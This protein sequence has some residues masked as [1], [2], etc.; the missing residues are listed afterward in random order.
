MD[1]VALAVQGHHDRGEQAVAVGR[2]HEHFQRGVVDTDPADLDQGLA[3][4]HRHQ[5]SGLPGQLLGAQADEALIGH[6]RELAVDGG[7]V[8]TLLAHQ[9]AH[10]V[11][12]LGHTLGGGHRMLQPF[13]QRAPGGEVKVGQQAILPGVPQFRAGAGNIGTGQQ[14]QVVQAVAAADQGGEAMD[15]HRVG[16]VL[17]LRGHRHAQVL[18]D[19]PGDQFGIGA[20][21]RMCLAE[22]ARVHRT[23]LGVVAAAA[24]GNVMEQAGQQQ[25]LRLAQARPHF[26][27]DREALVGTAAGEQADVA[28]D[29]QR[30]LVDGVD[31]EQVELHAPAD[32]GERG[33]PLAKH[34]QPRH[35]RKRVDRALATQ[36]G[37]EVLACVGVGLVIGRQQRQR[38]GQRTRGQ[39]VQAAHLR[40]VGP[41]GKQREHLAN[42]ALRPVGL[43]GGQV[44]TTQGKAHGQ[45]LRLRL[46]V[47]LLLEALQQA[48]ADPPHHQRGAVEALHHF[49]DT[50][51]LGVVFEAQARGEGLLVIETQALFRA[52]CY[53]VQAKPQSRQHGTFALERRGF[54]GTQMAEPDQGF[55][56]AHAERAQCHPAQ[57]VE[58]AQATGAILQVRLQVVGGIT[59]ALV[60]VAQLFQLG[61]EESAC[62]PQ[63]AIVDGLAQR[64]AGGVIGQDRTRLD[65]RGQHGLV[66]R[67]LAALQCR[68]HR[69]A[70]RQPAVPQQREQP[71][72]GRFVRQ[73]RRRIAEYQ[74]VDV[75]SREQFTAAIA[76]YREQRQAAA[77]RQ[78]TLP[79]QADQVV[80]SARTQR[81]QALDVVALVEAAVQA[82]VGLLQRLPRRSG[83]VRV[84][85]RRGRRVQQRTRRQHRQETC[86]S[87]GDRVST[88]TPVSVTATMCSHCADSLR[89]L[90]TTVQP[91]GSTL[92]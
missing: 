33:N 39:R 72:Q 69:M 31:M 77:G 70:D 29:H 45:R 44:A 17:L 66:S 37:K 73:L 64:A 35:A 86:D 75:R 78:A 46:A 58:I 59:E 40:V 2:V 81:Q 32:L 50:E 67:R 92:L 16:N 60:T 28:Q 47:E 62:R 15:H 34:A 3:L 23:Q 88:S 20:T 55:Q 8:V 19:Q 10:A 22:R 9:C 48:V 43:V 41:A 83:P 6:H 84:V 7:I 85:E 49:L 12:R 21:E 76:A 80:G 11:T 53:Q 27:R 14:I 54:V 82:C 71:R 61:Q 5:R 87:P 1:P 51:A 65:Q 4:L 90:V 74:Q 18:F 36:Q 26:V 79:R 57:R 42:V 24:L 63:F 68:T 52:T 25:Q 13:A 38:L 56:V 30:V 91:S 89:S